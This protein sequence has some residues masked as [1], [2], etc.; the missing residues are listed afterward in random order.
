[1]KIDELIPEYDVLTRHR[2]QVRASPKDVW[3]ALLRSDFSDSF[4][5][6]ILMSVRSG[7]VVRR[8]ENKPLRE[9]LAGTGFLELAEVPRQ[10]LVLGVAGRF[11]RPDGGRCFDV[12]AGEFP[13]F[14]RRG[15]AKAAWNFAV[16]SQPGGC[17]L[18]TETR[19][20]CFGRSALLSFRAYWAVVR[21]FSGLI[22]RAILQQVKRAAESGRAR[23]ATN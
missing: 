15:Y 23:G 20:Q 19:V 4:L 16:A 7:R 10:E 17:L 22:R 21:P 2:V 13:E 9:R 8:Q 5:V 6:R 12:T 1:M 14:R 18:S 11:W 3:N